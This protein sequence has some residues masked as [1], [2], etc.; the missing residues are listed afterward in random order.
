MIRLD[1]EGS[2]I[3]EVVKLFDCE[4]YGEGLLF[5]LRVVLLC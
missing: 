4:D 3:D 5:Q 2:P 1:Q